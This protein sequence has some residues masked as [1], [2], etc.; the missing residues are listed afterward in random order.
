M[1]MKK[2]KQK[3]DMEVVFA[4]FF[5]DFSLF[6]YLF[7]KKNFHS[8]FI[9]IIFTWLGNKGDQTLQGVVVGGERL[10]SLIF[11]S[12]SY[13]GADRHSHVDGKSGTKSMYR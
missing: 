4:C 9:P 12:P 11:P 7:I 8:L 13:T 1:V 3:F 6:I 2:K 5:K 10:R